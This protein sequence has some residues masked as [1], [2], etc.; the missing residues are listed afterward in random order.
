MQKIVPN[1]WFANEAEEA[2]R[3][4]TSVFA[5]GSAGRVTRHDEA[6][7]EVSGQPAGSVLAVE[8]EI[9]GCE[10][11][12]IN[13]GSIFKPNP[14]IS[15]FISRDTKEEIDALWE[16]L[17]DGGTALM[18]LDTYPF[19]DRY[20]WVQ[21]R[22]GVSWQLILPKPS[23]DPRPALI[24]SL[25][26]VGEVCGKVDEAID[27]YTSVFQDAQR[28][29]T[30]RYGAEHPAEEAENIMYADFTL[31]GQW[32]VAM[33]SALAHDFAFSEGISLLI[34]CETQDEID[35][36]WEQLS[37]QPDAAQ[38]GWVKDRYGV[39]WQIAPTILDEMLAD[40][41]PE[42]A[43]RVMKAMLPMK[44]LDIEELQRAYAGT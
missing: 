8:F 23:G 21:D 41:D 18:P 43:G 1:L 20:G 37:A 33:E 3:F 31:A 24:P 14:S 42:K 7:A 40:P 39:S 19:S 22:Y 30:V 32:F 11:V 10:F 25:L 12:G 28:G 26:F 27:F 2:A 15:F 4:Y 34:R 17:I 38:C 36:Y 13:G 16:R 29:T 9:E 35:R 44:K 5:D 6:S